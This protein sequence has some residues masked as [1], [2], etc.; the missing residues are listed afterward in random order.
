MNL[1]EAEDVGPVEGDAPLVTPPRPLHRRVSV[2]LLFT[3][4]VLIGT[5]VAIYMTFPA[6]N[7]VLVTEAIAQHKDPQQSWDLTAPSGPELRA[8][9]I[10]IAGKDAPMPATDV[11]VL[12]AR[13]IDVLNRGAAL[14]R[15]QVGADD[16]TYLIQRARGFAPESTDRKDGDLRAIAWRRGPF[17]CVAVGPASTSMTWRAAFP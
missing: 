9:A 2:S 16:V 14:M 12:G 8:W 7:N 11:K 6:R 3:L 5:V 4:T 15:L 10:G 1:V 17:T 13:R